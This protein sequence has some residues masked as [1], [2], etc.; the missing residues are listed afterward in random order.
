MF[1]PKH[2]TGGYNWSEEEDSTEAEGS[3]ASPTWVPPMLT[4][5]AQHRDVLGM[6]TL[7]NG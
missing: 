6:G 4:G 3:H 2:Q 7:L 1:S 5:S